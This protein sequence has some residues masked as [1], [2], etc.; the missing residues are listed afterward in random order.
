M[1]R[2]LLLSAIAA[3][4]AMGAPASAQQK[5][6]K[7]A[8]I[9]DT[10]GPLEAYAKQSVTGFKL[11]LEYATKGTMTVA[12]RKIELIEKDSQGKADV[13]RTLLG[14]ALG[15]D[16]ADIAVGGTSSAVALAML[17]VAAEAKK[18]LLVEPAVADSITGDKWNRYIFRTGRNSTQDAVSNALA[19]GKPGT[20]VATLGQ[21]YA[22]GRD[23]VAAF[24]RALEPTGAKIVGEEYAPPATTDFTAVAQRL[25]DTLDK[26]SGRKVIWVIWAGADPMAKL[27][28]LDP[29]KHGIELASGGSIL[30]AMAGWKS[31]AGMEGATYYYYAI[32]KNPVNDW[33]VAEHQKRF[34]APPDF[35]TAG[36]MAAG[37]AVVAA[38]EKTG[39]KSDT[40]SLIKAMEGISFETPKGTMIFRPEDHQALQSMYGFK[41][42]DDPAVKWAVPVLTREFGIADISLPIANK[43]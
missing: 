28:A 42:K 13:G 2:H 20:V 3:V 1:R 39:G 24:R 43:R 21:D 38:L 37:I 23:G 25:F 34:S 40:E 19:V 18:I 8:L 35:F 22:F 10:T 15:G 6:V 31:L 5:P 11:G 41:L 7:V 9:E 27:Q 36:G 4:F 30:P 32:P 14:E 33:L 12:G 29:A 16:D 17:P 26:Q